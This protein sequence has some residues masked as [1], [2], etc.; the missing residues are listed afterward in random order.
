MQEARLYMSGL[1]YTYNP[2]RLLL[3]RVTKVRLMETDGSVSELDN[4]KLYRVI[5]GLYSCQMLGAV[6]AESMGL[7]K[8]LPKDQNG[9]PITDFEEHIVY[10]NG[11]ELKE[12]V[13][14]ANYLISF[15]SSGGS[16]KIPEYYNRLQGRK[17]EDNSRSPAA[18]LKS[19]NKIFFILT[20]A[21]L[22]ILA[23]II[24]PVCLIIRALR[25]K[26]NAKK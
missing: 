9:K 3:N 13:A 24:V 15:E 14:L 17:T 12:W 20:G 18:L 6:E 19:P 1:S 22:L 11:T 8:V 25:R 23:I 7:L 26:K 16:S 21:I 2:H 5:G 10:D 4:N